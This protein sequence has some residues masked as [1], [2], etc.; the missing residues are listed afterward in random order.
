MTSFFEALLRNSTLTSLDLS[1]DFEQ[2]CCDLH[3]FDLK[4]F[5]DFVFVL[6]ALVVIV[7]F[8]SPLDPFRS[9]DNKFRDAGVTSFCEALAEN[10]TL[11]SLK[12]SGERITIPFV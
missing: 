11:Q 12:L 5:Q 6:G 2:D 8:S 10:T 9:S 1:G 7:D 3:C 4:L